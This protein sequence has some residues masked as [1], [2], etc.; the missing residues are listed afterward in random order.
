VVAAAVHVAIVGTPQP[1]PAEPWLYLGGPLGVVYIFV[2]AAI[3]Q[4][5]G[6]LLLGLGAVVGQLLTSVVL[7][8][9]WP[10]PASPGVAQ[11]VAMVVLALA[12]VVVAA[13][14]WR[15]LRR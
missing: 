15:S 3:V 2:S 13:V 12:S 5:T 9:L 1:L 14:P 8:A 11:E 4:Y 6:V 7:D 10:A